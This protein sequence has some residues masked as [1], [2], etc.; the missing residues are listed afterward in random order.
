MPACGSSDSSLS[1]CLDLQDGRLAP[2]HLHYAAS[3]PA[4]AIYICSATYGALEAPENGE[5]ARRA[6]Q[7]RWAVRTATKRRRE[8]M[9]AATCCGYLLPLPPTSNARV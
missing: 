1:A 2:E 8:E 3:M 4:S 5:K 6:G 7:S 9:A